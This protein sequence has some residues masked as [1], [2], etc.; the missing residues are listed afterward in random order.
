MVLFI[1]YAA[2]LGI[3]YYYGYKDGYQ[4]AIEDMQKAKTKRR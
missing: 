1:C 4:K 2:G 3:G